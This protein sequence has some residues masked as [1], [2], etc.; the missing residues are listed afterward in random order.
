MGNQAS[1]VIEKTKE[2]K[3]KRKVRRRSTI[4]VS[5]QSH[6]SLQITP[7]SPARANYDWLDASAPPSISSS[8]STSNTQTVSSSGSQRRRSVS[9]LFAKRKQSLK[10]TTSQDEYKEND[11]LQR[12]VSAWEIFICIVLQ[13]S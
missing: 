9:E 5:A 8:M 10:M 7:A 1:K 6:G 11:R 13:F 4:S 2:K 12:L 3:E